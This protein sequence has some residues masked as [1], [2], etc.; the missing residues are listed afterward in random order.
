MS[1]KETV[2]EVGES[3]ANMEEWIRMG[4]DAGVR[5]VAVEPKSSIEASLGAASTP[6]GEP[7]IAVKIYFDA[8]DGAAC[9]AA[10]M[11]V[12]STFQSMRAWAAEQKAGT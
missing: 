3:P 11:K 1:E 9:I 5:S 4:F 12:Q 2:Y 10:M 8:V 6:K 7:Q